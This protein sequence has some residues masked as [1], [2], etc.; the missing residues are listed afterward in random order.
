MFSL[1]IWS[2]MSDI[3]QVG[4]NFD[5]SD[6]IP[7]DL[8]S[9][10]CL[11]CALPTGKRM[12]FERELFNELNYASS[13]TKWGFT[14]IDIKEHLNRCVVE[15]SSVIPI[16]QLLVDLVNQLTVYMNELDQYRLT[17]RNERSPDT[18]QAYVSMFKELRMT[19]ADLRKVTT[20]QQLAEQIKVESISPLIYMMLRAVIEQVKELRE[21][22]L[23]RISKED[24][25]KM[26]EAFRRILK[27]WGDSASAQHKQ[28]L[29]KLAEILGVNSKEL[30]E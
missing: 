4:N 15:R 5:P 7:S 17:M 29:T 14:L 23:M 30:T 26:D 19:V 2:S 20:P 16:G 28:A 12:E 27:N 8:S 6:Y 9:K 21:Y 1:F 13:A 24:K 10:V 25:G 22:V 3:D 11:I 18:M